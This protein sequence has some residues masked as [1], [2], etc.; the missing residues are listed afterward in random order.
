MAEEPK[1]E[2]TPGFRTPPISEN[3]AHTLEILETDQFPAGVDLAA[4]LNGYYYAVW[5]ELGYQ[6]NRKTFSLL[7][8]LFQM[9]VAAAQQAGPAFPSRNSTEM[10]PGCNMRELAS[11]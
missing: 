2:V 10:A 3:P 8:Q 5:L 7:Y 9:T 1:Y 6:W 11:F 4:T